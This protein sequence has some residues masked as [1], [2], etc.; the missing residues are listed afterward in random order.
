MN[1][2]DKM[3]SLMNSIRC[4]VE[5]AFEIALI[6]A[7]KWVGATRKD[8]IC[9]K[10]E[11]FMKRKILARD[12]MR[13]IIANAQDMM[14]KSREVGSGYSEYC[15]LYL[16]LDEFVRENHMNFFKSRS[17]KDE[18]YAMRMVIKE[19]LLLPSHNVNAHIWALQHGIDPSDPS[20]GMS[21]TDRER[22]YYY[23]TRD[24]VQMYGYDDTPFTMCGCHDSEKISE[25]INELVAFDRW[26]PGI[27][28]E[29]VLLTPRD[30]AQYDNHNIL[31][32]RNIWRFNRD[33]GTATIWNAYATPEELTYEDFHDDFANDTA[34]THFAWKHDMA[35]TFKLLRNY[36]TMFSAPQLPDYSQVMLKIQAKTNDN[37]MRL[38]DEFCGIF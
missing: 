1:T 11:G 18:Y 14:H 9:K 22:T 5:P 36:N 28:I 26:G 25:E 4:V 27:F 3:Y 24:Q 31:R 29:N 13:R 34:D 2:T 33:T 23:Q 37:C 30:I 7:Q 6:T 35:S 21:R 20:F 19:Y 38:I 10:L 15:A 12:M 8:E 16:S 17:C 32:E